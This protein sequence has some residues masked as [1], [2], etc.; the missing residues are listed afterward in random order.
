MNLSLMLAE[1]L[2]KRED[3]RLLSGYHEVIQPLRF[4]TASVVAGSDCI[5]ITKICELVGFTFGSFDSLSVGPGHL[6]FYGS[7]R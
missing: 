7:S 2:L 5:R 4:S 6:R 1:F 3:W